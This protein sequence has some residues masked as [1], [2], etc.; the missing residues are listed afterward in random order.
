MATFFAT[1]K[2][3]SADW[4]LL[5]EYTIPRRQK[6]LD[7][8]LL[9][10]ELII[11]VEFKTGDR[12]FTLGGQRQVE[13]YAL[14]LRDFHAASHGR[15]IVPILVSLRAP[16][17]SH[18]YDAS[19]NDLVKGVALANG[20]TLGQ[21]VLNAYD[22]LHSD[23]SQPI[24]GATW[25]EAPYRPVPTIIE[26][27]RAIFA[28]HDV[29]QI[30]QSEAGATNLTQTSERLLWIVGESLANRWKTICF[31]TGVPGAGK[32][33]AGLNV[34]HNA[35][36]HTSSDV[37]AVFLSGNGPLV[38]VVGA[39]IQRDARRRHIEDAGRASNAFI[40]NVHAFIRAEFPRE[41]QPP[42]E[43][44]IIFDEAQRAWDAAHNLRKNKH[45][46]SEPD[47]LLSIANRHDWAVVIALVG[48]G[49]E[50]NTGEAGLSEWGRTLRNRFPHWRVIVSPHALAGGTSVSGN[51]LFEDG[52]HGSLNVFSEP[53]LH[54]NVNI[55]SYRTDRLANWV[56]A[57]LSGRRSDAAAHTEQL[58][59]RFPIVLT[60]SLDT[61]RRWL[62][63]N[64]RGER[65]C[66]LVA[67]SGAVR[68]RPHGLELSS[69]FRLGN[70]DMFVN[71]FLNEPSDIR[72]S[73]Q[74]EVAA[75]EYECQGLELDWLGL[76]W[77]GDF[78][79]DSERNDWSYRRFAGKS[80]GEARRA[81]DRKY[82]LNTYRVLLTRAREG[83]VI[84]IP[85]GDATDETRPPSWFESTTT[86]LKD[87]G[88][89]EL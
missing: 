12:T 63:A 32:T 40:Q 68:L 85:H 56:E 54:L 65:R 74:L 18:P 2:P 29:R 76:C 79:F 35:A 5:L 25:E 21:V 52:T 17:P 62:R 47:L 81:D 7:A 49:Q 72:A 87:C 50:I 86:Y 30:A 6:R 14:D 73:N 59:R 36:L 15:Q 83:M 80:W 3:E 31:V 22:L 20:Q 38:K 46:V 66:G 53:A 60:R 1:E 70:R 69:G 78:T 61:A 44:V 75:S 41:Q 55:R 57:V 82:V 24:E 51:R 58:Q 28:G 10:H 77:G 89:P 27:T 43:H 48:G 64:T 4:T 84:W 16:D 88:M 11:A 71:W 8:V 67:S 42:N 9:A 19:G 23:V 37:N 34:A 26:A 39:A 13:D 45:D 33:L